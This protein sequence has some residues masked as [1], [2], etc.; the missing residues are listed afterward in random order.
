MN[1]WR[2]WGCTSSVSLPFIHSFVH[3]SIRSIIHSCI[4]AV[5]ARWVIHSANE[6]PFVIGSR[7]TR[8]LG[9][10][11][12]TWW[13][14]LRLTSYMGFKNSYSVRCSGSC[15][16]HGPPNSSTCPCCA[17]PHPADSVWVVEVAD[18][19]GPRTP[20]CPHALQILYETSTCLCCARCRTPA[21][22]VRDCY[23]V[24]ARPGCALPRPC[25]YCHA[26]IH[27]FNHSFTH[28]LTLCVATAPCRYCGG[29][30]HSGGGAHQGGPGGA[31]PGS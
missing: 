31:Y 19:M 2:R 16:L 6:E 26:C 10:Q 30:L 27:S 5:Q 7:C 12:P 20:T 4:Q 15:W 11:P 8:L 1:S 9:V 24:V 25:G 18:C 3:S 28:S 13:L 29:L 17:L 23:I 21:A 22:I 14:R